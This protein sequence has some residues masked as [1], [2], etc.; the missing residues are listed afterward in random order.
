MGERPPTFDG[1]I[2]DADMARLIEEGLVELEDEEQARAPLLPLT[3]RISMQYVARFRDLM[4]DAARP[5]LD[6]VL[7]MFGEVERLARTSGDHEA[8]TVLS[9]LP[10]LV[11]SE[12]VES[13]RPSWLGRLK[14]WVKSFAA[15]V[16]DRQE[17]R[18]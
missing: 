10:S 3:R 17:P 16:G 12:E 4:R 7:Q 5:N 1:P 11:P 6:I 14:G 15:V 9:S 13:P 18:P 8:Q 2:T